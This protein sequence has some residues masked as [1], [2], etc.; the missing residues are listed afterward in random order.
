MFFFEEIG[1]RTVE[2]T[3]LECLRRLRNDPST[4]SFLGDIDLIDAEAQRQWFQRIRTAKDRRYYVVYDSD[5]DTMGIVRMD[6]IDRA[7]RSIRIG[8]DLLPEFRGRGVGKRLYRLLLKYCFDYLNMHRV[9]LAVLD[10]N[11][12]ALELYR[13]SGFREEGRYREAIFRDAAYHDYILMSILEDE[14]RA[15]LEGSEHDA[16]RRS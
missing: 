11:Q 12:R 1:V 15:H 9:W 16:E 6:A 14:Y 2:D 5:H 3:D 4:W 13:S 10:S 8:A 7:N